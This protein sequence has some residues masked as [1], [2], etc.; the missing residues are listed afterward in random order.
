VQDSVHNVAAASA[1]GL[2]YVRMYE[3]DEKHDSV[4]SL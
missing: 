3:N 1:D 2:G 4:A